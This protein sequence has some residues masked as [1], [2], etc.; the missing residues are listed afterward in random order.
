MHGWEA[1]SFNDDTWLSSYEG[2]GLKQGHQPTNALPLLASSPSLG[3][4]PFRG[5]GGG[6][7]ASS[8]VPRAEQELHPILDTAPIKRATAGALAEVGVLAEVE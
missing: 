1:S 3:S 4:L 8:A 7:P 5:L 6:A 2:V